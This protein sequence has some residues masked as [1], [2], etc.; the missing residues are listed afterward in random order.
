M[1]SR[2]EP[3]CPGGGRRQKQRLKVFIPPTFTPGLFFWGTRFRAAVLFS[4]TELRGPAFLFFGIFPGPVCDRADHGGHGVVERRDRGMGS[5]A[6]PSRKRMR[7]PPADRQTSSKTR[8]SVLVSKTVRSDFPISHFIFLNF[9]R[10][11]YRRGPT[12]PTSDQTYC[13][14]GRS[15]GW[16]MGDGGDGS[17]PSEKRMSGGSIALPAAFQDANLGLTS[18]TREP[19]R[20]R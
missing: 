5:G 10:E 11:P 9:F 2:G 16:G 15:S 20:H 8:T 14:R 17:R 12:A 7:T 4:R 13:R 19:G 1:I 6:A 18:S 3:Y